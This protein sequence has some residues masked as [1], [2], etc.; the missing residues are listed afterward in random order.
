M[1]DR[2]HDFQQHWHDEV[3]LVLAEN[4]EW[5]RKKQPLL[6]NSIKTAQDKHPRKQIT[7]GYKTLRDSKSEGQVT[8]FRFNGEGAE[9]VFDSRLEGLPPIFQVQRCARPLW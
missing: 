1:L 2:S 8:G 7:H 6:E 5:F 4:F 9:P 3:K